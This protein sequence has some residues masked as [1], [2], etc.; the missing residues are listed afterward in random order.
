MHADSHLGIGFPI[1]IPALHKPYQQRIAPSDNGSSILTHTAVVKL[2]QGVPDVPGSRV[3]APSFA[4][5]G[6]GQPS[7]FTR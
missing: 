7:S 6:L 4:N 3:M 1:Q 5:K 2:T